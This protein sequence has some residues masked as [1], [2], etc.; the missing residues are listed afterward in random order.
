[1]TTN[2]NNNNTIGIT[3]YYNNT[4]YNN[5]NNNNNNNLSFT[6]HPLH[7]MIAGYFEQALDSPPDSE[8]SDKD[9]TISI[10][11]NNLHLP[12]TQ[13]NCKLVCQVLERC[14]AL[15]LEGKIATKWMV[16]SDFDPNH[17][18]SCPPVILLDDTMTIKCINEALH[19]QMPV[20]ATAIFLNSARRVA[21]L[22]PVSKS[23]ICGLLY[24]LGAIHAPVR[25]RQQGSL[26]VGMAWAQQQ[27]GV[28]LQCLIWAS[29]SAFQHISEADTSLK[30][31]VEQY[32]D[33][34]L[35]KDN[36]KDLKEINGVSDGD[37]MNNTKTR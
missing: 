37:G 12:P 36:N 10:I 6:G 26:E 14:N 18:S 1:M 22:E 11:I 35:N 5:N 33:D 7:V 15:Q 8:W 16:Y 4:N 28:A 24:Q 13:S 34:L 31:H 27:W 17:Q 19:L 32:L 25:R 30:E 23:A 29:D 9:E 3:T 2:T 20:K 21:G